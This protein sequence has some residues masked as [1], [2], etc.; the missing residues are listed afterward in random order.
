[1]IF[2]KKYGQIS[3]YHEVD[4]D[5]EQYIIKNYVKGNKAI[6]PIHLE[7][8]DELYSK[9]HPDKLVLNPDLLEYIEKVVYYIPYR[10]SIV[11]KISGINFTEEE[12][13][14]IV[15]LLSEHF[16]MRVHDKRVDIKFNT[17]KA[18]ILFILGVIILYTSFLLSNIDSIAF[19]TEIV[20]IA[21]TFAIW[22][23]VN[24]LWLERS[25]LKVARLNAGQ[26]ACSTIEFEDVN[27]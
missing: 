11:L 7:N 3:R 19:I 14:A 17:H 24:T 16:G 15:K 2:R 23:L 25:G 4:F 10:F 1:M 20:S 27:Y 26:L 6:I 18:I 5:N 13:I 22:E 9:Y 8:K 21:G 12:K